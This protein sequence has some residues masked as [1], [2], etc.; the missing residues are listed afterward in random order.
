VYVVS[1]S[2]F[3]RASPTFDALAPGILRNRTMVFNLNPLIIQELPSWLPD[4]G[5]PAA[6]A[7]ETHRRYCVQHDPYRGFLGPAELELRC[8]HHSDGM[9]FPNLIP[10]LRALPQRCLAVDSIFLRLD[11]RQYPNL[12]RR[13]FVAL[14]PPRTIIEAAQAFARD[15]FENQPYTALHLRTGDFCAWPAACEHLAEAVGRQ[16]QLMQQAPQC[17]GGAE[18]LLLLTDDWQHNVT[19]AIRAS[20]PGEVVAF[21][22]PDGLT[23]ILVEQQ[24]G[25][26]AACFVGGGYSTFSG[27]IR[28]KRTVVHDQPANTTWQY[29][30]Q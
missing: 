6:H 8:A 26:M 27:L 5:L 22:H 13:T 19:K 4:D 14:E 7:P 3:K 2:D 12:F 9:I 29:E 25:A 30:L 18:R 17:V 16:L 20:F 1:G 10:L 15:T 23:S 24:L 28:I 21:A 11:W